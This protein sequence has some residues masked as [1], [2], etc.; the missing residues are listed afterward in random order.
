MAKMLPL[1]VTL[2]R[3]H[4]LLEVCEPSDPHRE[5]GLKWKVNRRGGEARAGKWAGSRG[6]KVQRTGENREDWVVTMDGKHYYVARIIYFM[7][8]GVDPY[9]FQVDHKNQDSRDNR[10]E[11]LRLADKPGLQ[12]Q[13]QGISRN[14]KSGIKGV[15]WCKARKKWAVF[16]NRHYLGYFTTLKEAAAAKNE[17]VKKYYLKETWEANF[18]DLDTITD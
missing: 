3:C 16:V 11:N 4:E 5:S 10:I 1:R 15:S 9:P 13:N 14:N 8:H 6:S 2:K 7:V 17:G 18:V 12:Q